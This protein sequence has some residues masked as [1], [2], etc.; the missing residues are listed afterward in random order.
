M[1]SGLERAS[2]SMTRVPASVLDRGDVVPVAA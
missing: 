1:N 2:L